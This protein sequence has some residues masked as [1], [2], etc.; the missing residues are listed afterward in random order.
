MVAPT[1][2]KMKKIAAL[3]ALGEGLEPQFLTSTKKHT[4]ATSATETNAQ[5][6]FDDAVKIFSEVGIK[7]S[8]LQK[9]VHGACWSP[10]R[11]TQDWTARPR[12]RP[13]SLHP[14]RVLLVFIPLDITALPL[15]TDQ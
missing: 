4:G 10:F 2:Q 14:H 5:S 6:I 7:P 1:S 12:G 3:R 8:F 13:L 11:H 15:S 9:I